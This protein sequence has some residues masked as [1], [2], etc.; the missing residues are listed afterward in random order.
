[1]S[2]CVAEIKWGD[3]GAPAHGDSKLSSG[4]CHKSTSGGSSTLPAMLTKG[5]HASLGESG[6]YSTRHIHGARQKTLQSSSILVVIIYCL[7]HVSLLAFLV[8]SCVF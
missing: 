6:E 7:T 4:Q 5:S 8:C 2:V 3:D 1:M